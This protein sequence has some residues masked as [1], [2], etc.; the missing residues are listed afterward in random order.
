[1]INYMY[2][3]IKLQDLLIYGAKTKYWWNLKLF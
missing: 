2:V 1:M 3:Q